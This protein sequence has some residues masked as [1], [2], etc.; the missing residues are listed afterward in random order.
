M[1]C[2][3][4]ILVMGP[5]HPSVDRLLSMIWSLLDF[6]PELKEQIIPCRMHRHDDSEEI[7]KEMLRR[8]A[9]GKTTPTAMEPKAKTELTLD[10]K[11]LFDFHK[12][13]K[14][15]SNHKY[16]SNKEHSLRHAAIAF[17]KQQHEAGAKFMVSVRK[18]KT[19]ELEE[20]ATKFTEGEEETEGSYEAYSTLL[21]YLSDIEHEGT[22]PDSW[23]EDRKIKF[24]RCLTNCEREYM[25]SSRLC[26]STTNAAAG[27]LA[28]KWFGANGNGIIAIIDEASMLMDTE[29]GVPMQ[30]RNWEKVHGMIVCGDYEQMRPVIT[31]DTTYP[32]VNEF[33]RN[34]L[35]TWI[36]RALRQGFPMHRLKESHRSHMELLEFLS[37]NVYGGQLGADASTVGNVMPINLKSALQVFT[38]AKK[39]TKWSQLGFN[40]TNPNQQTESGTSSRFNPPAV[41]LVIELLESLIAQHALP[42]STVVMTPYQAE[43]AR[44]LAS[45]SDLAK[46]VNFPLGS[47]PP[48]L[49]VYGM[50]GQDADL[51]IFDTTV[52][53]IVKAEDLG[54]VRDKRLST[55]ALTRA[56]LCLLVIA[57]GKLSTLKGSKTDKKDFWDD[58][59]Q[60]TKAIIGQVILGIAVRADSDKS[61]EFRWS[62]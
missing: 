43:F 52:S 34:L 2:G 40:L 35:T 6:I 27:N 11:A 54:I 22:I 51:I 23:L 9:A 36:S 8:K 18:E 19:R 26:A 47:M 3:L 29:F 58:R 61:T 33:S 46:R 24:L 4:D 17:A 48:V 50:Q 41:G 62:K 44:I 39:L 55:V 31:T 32:L 49:T 7:L 16:Q 56:K 5:T 59:L 10:E 45:V 13:Y 21:S 28:Q 12:I 38:E 60:D 20:G 53:G 42:E 30:L 14:D 25:K 37:Q 57:D 15:A 1:L